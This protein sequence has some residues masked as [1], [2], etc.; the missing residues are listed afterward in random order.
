MEQRVQG[1][2]EPELADSPGASTAS[3]PRPTPLFVFGVTRSGTSYTYRTLNAHPRIRLTYEG[4][5]AKEGAYVYA[6]CGNL[7]DRRQFQG[8]IEQLGSLEAEVP[9]NRW[10]LETILAHADELFQQHSAQPSFAELIQNI[11]R[12]AGDVD[13]WGSKLLRLEMCPEILR[14]WPQARLIILV[15]DPR[16]VFFSQRRVWHARPRYSAIYWTLHSSLTRPY[17]QEPARAVIVRYED[18][19]RD[20][21]GNLRKMLDLVGLW[22]QA[23][24]DRIAQESPPDPASLEKWRGLL[25]PADVRTVEEICFDEM[26]AWGYEPELATAQRQVG[27]WTKGVET[28]VHHRKLVRFDLE[29]LRRKQIWRRFLT[30]VRS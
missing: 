13:C 17:V 24:A 2:P 29:W 4:R 5:I 7:G 21:P 22:D 27:R 14:H 11:Y 15:R 18:L 12:A 19:I 6:R 8:L 9:Q 10:V 25:E 28:L 1:K 23:V 26:K 30:T 20:F 3:A 16:A